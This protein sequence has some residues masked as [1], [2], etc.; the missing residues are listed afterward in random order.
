MIIMGYLLCIT[1]TVGF[2]LCAHVPKDLGDNPE[3]GKLF[4]G[5]S[6]AIRFLQGV[7]DSMVATAAYSIVSIEFPH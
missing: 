6:L 4:F 3:N 2:G 7:G 1:A 5:L